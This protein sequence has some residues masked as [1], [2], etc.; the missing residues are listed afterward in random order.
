MRA[1]SSA[2]ACHGWITIAETH[3]ESIELIKIVGATDALVP[4]DYDGIVRWV[5][6]TQREWR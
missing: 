2:I 1:D 5:I 6:G 4:V 3:Q